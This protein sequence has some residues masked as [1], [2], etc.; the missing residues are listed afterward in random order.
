[1]RAIRIMVIIGGVFFALLAYG[2]HWAFY[3]LER[4]PKGDLL[5]ESLSPDG[6][7]T[8]RIYV[9]DAGATT[10]FSTVGELMDHQS[11][12]TRN[13]YFQYK[14]SKA[15]VEWLDSDTVVING[16]ELDVPCEVYDYRRT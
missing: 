14:E 12:Q 5:V 8:V 16:R 9:S 6:R 13:I 7:Y 4:I 2:I 1:M 10:S 15:I 11:K 3:D